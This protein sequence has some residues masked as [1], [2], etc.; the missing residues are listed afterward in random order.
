MQKPVYLQLFD[1]AKDSACNA[2]TNDNYKPLWKYVAAIHR[3][4]TENCNK[5][6][7][8]TEETPNKGREQKN[9]TCE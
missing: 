3:P 1:N 4:I 5:T 9:L 6:T 2:L 7:A 8:M